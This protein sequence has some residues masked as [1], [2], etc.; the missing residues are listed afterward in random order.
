MV[1]KRAVISC[2]ELK[3]L[4][5]FQAKPSGDTA[6]KEEDSG[7]SEREKCEQKKAEGEE[8]RDTEEEEE[9]EEEEEGEQEEE[10]EDEE[11]EEDEEVEEVVRELEMVEK[12]SV[13]QV[14]LC[15][16][17]HMMLFYL[18]RL[19]TYQVCATQTLEGWTQYLKHSLC[20]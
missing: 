4:A 10:T 16:Y 12:L 11:E 9:E 14:S 20:W 5:D 19:E 6:S 18:D 2:R 15:Q 8:E 17:R 7:S 1:I 13:D 3:D